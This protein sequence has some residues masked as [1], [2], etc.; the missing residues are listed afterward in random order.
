MLFLEISESF[1]GVIS[2]TIIY[3]SVRAEK[4]KFLTNGYMPPFVFSRHLHLQNDDWR[5]RLCASLQKLHP[6]QRPR[7]QEE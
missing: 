6:L 1:A 2:K 4:F 5:Q 7:G 3:V